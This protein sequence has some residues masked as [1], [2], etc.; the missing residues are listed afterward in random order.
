MTLRQWWVKERG[1][2]IG[3]IAV[4]TTAFAVLVVASVS[5]D[6]RERLPA[7]SGHSEPGPPVTPSGPPS[8]DYVIDL[9]T[10]AT[11]PL[12]K[13]IRR[14]RGFEPAPRRGRQYA[15]SP[16]GS[17]LAYVGT[18]DNGS[19]QIFIAGVDGAGV[20]Q[21]THDPTGAESPAW[22]PDGA[23]IAYEGHGSGTVRNL[24]VLDVATGESRQ[25]TDTRRD[26]WGPQFTPDGSS[27]L[28]T[29]GSFSAPVLRTVPATGGKSTLFI[30]P[31]EGVT[32]AGNG[33]LSP[34]GSFVTFIGGGRPLSGEV[35]H[36]GPCR[37]VA[38]ADGTERG[39][40]LGC[41][42]SSPA[43]TWS[44]DGRRIVCVDGDEHGIIVVHVGTGRAS[45]VAEGS[46]AIWL[47]RHTLLVEA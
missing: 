5:E 32:D 42:D 11:R 36:C 9:D 6:E 29:G 45:R 24:F 17:L 23:S 7:G 12:P 20:R 8:V 22:S 1:R 35:E 19:F 44:P 3:A 30:G 28:Y 25:V 47:D 14:S 33:S 2:A 27:L 37:W 18:S 31:G 4:V 10:G 41:F 26:L 15:A 21:V 43:G 38:H 13:T 16:G 34:D 46:S 40:L 39:V